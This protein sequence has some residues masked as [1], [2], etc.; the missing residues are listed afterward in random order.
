MGRAGLVA[1]H[2]SIR[3]HKTQPIALRLAL[4]LT[5]IAGALSG[6]QLL[7]G[8]LPAVV[9]LAFATGIVSLAPVVMYGLTSTVGVLFLLMYYQ[10]SFG[11]LITKT[12]LLQTLDSFLFVPQ[13]SHWIQLTGAAA[14]SLGAIAAKLVPLPKGNF[15]TPVTEPRLLVWLSV[16]LAV[17][18]LTRFPLEASG[19]AG[20]AASRFLSNYLVLAFVLATAATLLKT[21]GRAL[22]S[23]WSSFLGLAVCAESLAANSKT[24]I[25]AAGLSVILVSSCFAK[26]ISGR[27]LFWL[28]PSVAVLTIA[29]VPA[30]HLSRS[31]RDTATAGEMAAMTIDTAGKLLVGDPVARRAVEDLDLSTGLID[32]DAYRARYTGRDAA[33]YDRFILIG[34]IDGV[35]RRLNPDGPFLGLNFVLGRTLEILPIQ[36]NGEKQE[37]SPNDGLTQALALTSPKTHI[38][39]TVPVCVELFAAGGFTAAF[40][41]AGLVMFLA[42]SAINFVA[43]SF[44]YNV[45]G[46]ATLVVY[47]FYLCVQSYLGYMFFFFRQFPTDLIILSMALALARH[48]DRTVGSSS[49]A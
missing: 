9:L 18:S 27:H 35:A 48:L 1:S 3:D 21:E 14:F 37:L 31:H 26:R 47:G 24:G 12:L 20:I 25:F 2:R 5:A 13:F 28:I 15:L 39:I 8:T 43:Q 6:V 7:L 40:I 44:Y 45:W 41:V 17:L 29:I 30:V 49:V 16:I 19:G 33:W 34:F 38:F 36:L 46:C 10:F 42:A 4:T 32:Y 22:F 23:P 11:E